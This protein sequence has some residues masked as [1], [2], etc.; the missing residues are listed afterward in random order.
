MKEFPNFIFTAGCAS[1]YLWI[2]ENEPQMFQEIRQRVQEGRWVIVG[3]TWVQPDCNIPSGEAFARQYLY[4]Q[5]YFREKF[6]RIATV[7]Y[8]VDSFGHHGMLPQ[9]LVKSGL[10][11]Y[12]FSRPNRAD[13]KPEL[14]ASLF[15]WRSPDG[16]EV[17][18]YR[19]PGGYGE[20]GFDLDNYQRWMEEEGV[21]LMACYG[22]S[23]H[24]G[25]PTIARL[26]QLETLVGETMRYSSPDAYFDQVEAMKPQLRVVREDL[27]HHA[28]G[29]YSADSKAKKLNRLAQDRLLCAEKFGAM[30]R[31]LVPDT[32][33]CHGVTTAAW[34]ELMFYQFHDVLAGCCIRDASEDCEN[35]VGGVINQAAEAEQFALQRVCWHINTRRNGGGGVAQRNQW[36]FWEKEGEGA[37]VVVF[38]PHSFPVRRP[39]LLNTKQVSAVCDADGHFTPVQK[40]RARHMDRGCNDN[41]LFL[42]DVPAY[43]YRTYYVYKQLEVEAEAACPPHAEE[44]VLENK[45]L[46]V[47]F[48]REHGWIERLV[49]KR[50]GKTVNAGPLAR[51][52]L[53]NDSAHDTW[54]H[55]VFTFDDVQGCFGQPSFRVLDDGPVRAAVRVTTRYGASTLCQDYSLLEDSES[56]E[57]ACRLFYAQQLQIL[58]LTFDAA[59][60]DPTLTCAMPA[61][62]IEKRPDGVEEPAQCW[63]DVHDEQSGLAVFTSDKYSFNARGN[64]LGF[65]AA[66]SCCYADHFGVRDGLEEFQDLGEQSFCYRIFPHGPVKNHRLLMEDALL[67]RDVQWNMETYHDGPLSGAYCGFTCDQPGILLD[68]V[69][70]AEDG[71]G[72]VARLVCTEG[73]PVEARLCVLDRTA[74]LRFGPYEVKTVRF[75]RENRVVETNLL[76]D[77]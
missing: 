60:T 11:A 48:N 44:G 8:N 49:D 14:Q 22:V 3:G 53:V 58:R 9:Y 26:Q 51:A 16:S 71:N 24:G 63:A 66:R 70:E 27:Q 61:G 34:K 37:P 50:T 31:Q 32:P 39:V 15:T 43:G 18:G 28:S 10:R 47:E 36:R 45:H 23:N 73:E 62:V 76:E 29:C 21:P 2:E 38:N 5:R 69:K 6:G 59:V 30:S 40:V 12:V 35:A 20:K 68:A 41:F 13:E 52:E 57:V 42:A 1:Y 56:V 55:G 25:G 17:Y 4:A 72:I 19:I 7:G 33:S 77:M 54:A 65:I 75:T 64:R 67:R 74:T 46:R